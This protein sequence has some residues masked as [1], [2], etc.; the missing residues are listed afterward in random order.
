MYIM[1]YYGLRLEMWGKSIWGGFFL[2]HHGGWHG[3]Y[4]SVLAMAI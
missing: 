1:E 3:C 2:A 4:P